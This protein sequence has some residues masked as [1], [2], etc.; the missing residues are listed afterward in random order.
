MTTENEKTPWFTGGERPVREGVYEMGNV[1]PDGNCFDGYAYFDG[2][3]WGLRSKTPDD[4]VLSYSMF[5]SAPTINPDK[6]RGLAQCPQPDLF[7][8]L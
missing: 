4:A 5:G 2:Q 1:E 7:A 3:G 8:S 6:W